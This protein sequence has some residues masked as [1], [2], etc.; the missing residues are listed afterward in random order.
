MTFITHLK[1]NLLGVGRLKKITNVIEKI[2]K[3]ADRIAGYVLLGVMALVVVN[4]ILR[5]I[6]IKSVPGTIELV[7]I[8]AAVTGGLALAY[9]GFLNEHIEI[10]FIW[11]KF[12]KIIRFVTN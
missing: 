6:F 5:T 12:P 3:M 1:N 8:F 11:A 4:V 9:C 10:D 7:E 2:S